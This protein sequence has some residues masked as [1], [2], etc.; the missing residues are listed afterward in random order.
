MMSVTTHCDQH[1]ISNL[2]ETN[3]IMSISSEHKIKEIS[4]DKLDF[5]RHNPRLVAVEGLETASDEAIIKALINEADI[6]EL[7]QSIAANGYLDIESIIVTKKNA[8]GSDR[9]RVL[10]GNRR[11]C[12]VKLLSDPEL[13]KRCRFSLPEEIPANVYESLSKKVTSYLVEDDEEARTYI[14]FKHINGPYR[15]DSYAKAKFLVEWY[16]EKYQAGITI[17][18]IADKMGD[19]NSTVRALISGMLVLNQAESEKLFEISDRT[20]SG[21]FGF[22]HLYTALG[23]LEYRDYLGLDKDWNSRPSLKPIK[24]SYL[25]RLQTVL[26]F[27]YGSETNDINSVIKSQNPDLKSLGM[28]FANPVACQVLM[29]TLDL[30]KALERVQPQNEVFAN[31]LIIAHAKIEDTLG[32]TGKFSPQQNPDLLSMAEEISANADTILS[33]M[34]KKIEKSG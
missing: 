10:E 9:Y 5:D 31:A 4:W 1:N 26:H 15:W 8:S 28:V 6:G 11:L 34:N 22:S 23:R 32:K 27:I 3:K 20:K 14:G 2:I 17:E 19:K 12:S 18:E 13:A 25:E 30:S 21:S 7:V 16:E 33:A 24:D 29:T